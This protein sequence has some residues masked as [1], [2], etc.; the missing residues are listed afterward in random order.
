MSKSVAVSLSEAAIKRHAG[1]SA[2]TQLR[3]TQ[4]PLRF[5]YRQ[6]RERGSFYV[7]TRAQGKEHW[8]KLGNYPDLTVKAVLSVL[9]NVMQRL[10]IEPQSG[11][12]STSGWSTVGEV[13][14]WYTHRVA[15]DGNLS[16]N[17]KATARSAV[18]CQLLPCL[19]AL[20][21]VELN[22]ATLDTKL[23]WPLQS[24]YSVAH[25]R[26]VFGVLKEAATRVHRLS[27]QQ[28]SMG[29]QPK[30]IPTFDTFFADLQNALSGE[31]RPRTHPLLYGPAVLADRGL[32]RAVRLRAVRGDGQ[33]AAAA[34][35]QGHHQPQRPPGYPQML[36]RV[37]HRGDRHQVHGGWRQGK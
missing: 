11:A 31:V 20:R 5:R 18:K 19:G 37:P 1:D 25:V 16:K 7:V 17:R 9:P 30:Q 4:R 26:L 15:H 35:G 27:R 36:R 32:R 22:H 3:D 10:A 2:I 6:N 14:E 33:A 34:Q 12:L 13:L 29:L 28:L 24:Q 23:M 21:L 8:H